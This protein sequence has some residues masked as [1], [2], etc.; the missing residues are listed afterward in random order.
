M[1]DTMFRDEDDL[2]K[3]EIFKLTELY[4]LE[5]ILT[6]NDM[7]EGEAIYELYIHGAIILPEV[8]PL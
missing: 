6:F 1:E 4:S 8:T 2:I 7:N 3:E 5:D